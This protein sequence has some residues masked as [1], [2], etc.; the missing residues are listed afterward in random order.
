MAAN[1]AVDQM[2]FASDGDITETGAANFFLADDER[3]VTRHLD[4]SFLHGVTRDSVIRLA[5]HIGYEVEERTMGLDELVEWS[6]RGEAFLSGTAAVVAPV[7]TILHAGE[8]LTFGDGQPGR[9]TLRL[10]QAL[11]DIQAGA[12]PDPFGWRTPVHG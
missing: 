9:S 4:E 11:V 6:E 12:A 8:A 10:R 7:G 5:R 3:L 2:L 1:E